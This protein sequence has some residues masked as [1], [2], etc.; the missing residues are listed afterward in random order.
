MTNLVILKAVQAVFM[1]Y[2][3]SLTSSA[4]VLHCYFLTTKA[5]WQNLRE[6][7]D[8]KSKSVRMTVKTDKRGTYFVTILDAL[9]LRDFDFWF[10]IY[11]NMILIWNHSEN[12]DF[13]F[14]L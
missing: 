10:K 1:R 9:G 7:S 12:S 14:N 8:A 11:F 2:N 4:A 13:D 5:Q 6:T 3:T